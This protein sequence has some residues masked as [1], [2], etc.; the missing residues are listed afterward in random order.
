M[1]QLSERL[2]APGAA[3]STGCSPSE[4]YTA[5]SRCRSGVA[6]EPTQPSWSQADLRSSLDATYRTIRF[7]IPLRPIAGPWGLPSR[8]R[9]R[10]IARPT[11]LAPVAFAPPPRLSLEAAC[12]AS[13]SRA[14]RDAPLLGFPALQHMP[15]PRVHLR[16]KIRTPRYVP[17]SGFR[18]PRRLPPREPSRPCFMPERSWASPF[19]GSSSGSVGTSYEARHLHDVGRPPAVH[20][21]AERSARNRPRTPQ[22]RPRGFSSPESG[23]S[24]RLFASRRSPLPSWASSSLRPAIRPPRRPDLAAIPPWAS[25]R[26]SGLRPAAAP[27]LRGLR[28][29]AA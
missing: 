7:P 15:D 12:R 29:R 24:G 27:A 2:A 28:R 6:A 5:I 25:R 13:S 9:P 19:R 21:A 16:G 3:S 10:P 8:R 1:F 20:F 23:C 11:R 17:A 26:P 18:P 22:A 4:T 14:P